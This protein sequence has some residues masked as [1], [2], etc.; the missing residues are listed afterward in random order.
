IVETGAII[1]QSY[2][3]ARAIT[4]L[5]AGKPFD[6][7]L[8]DVGLFF[9][10][11]IIRY[12]FVQIE[13]AFA[14]KYARQ[15]GAYLRN[16]LLKRYFEKPNHLMQQ[17]GTGHLVELL[18]EGIDN[19]KKYVEIIAIRMFK[20]III[21]AATVSF[22]FYY[23]K[24]AAIILVATVPIVIIFMILLGIAAQKMADSQYTMY[25]RLANHFIDSLKGLET[26]AYLGKSKE[27]GKRIT[28]VSEDYRKS[29]MKTLRIAFL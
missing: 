24:T 20:T 10:M 18:M 29:T 22:I 16:T 1:A 2:F 17:M 14:E 9:I 26:L 12:I 6:H 19:V 28:A 8:T 13:D 3:L 11:F 4:F 25:T 23:D 27:H 15:T 7:V 5:F 21:P